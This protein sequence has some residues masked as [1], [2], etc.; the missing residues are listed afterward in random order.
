MTL[1]AATA[2]DPKAFFRE[3]PEPIRQGSSFDLTIGNI[4][5][6]KGREV[7][8]PFTLKAGH[9]V[10][11][12]SAQVFNLP[13]HITGHVTY[14]T[15]LTRKGIWALTV[16]IVD[17]GWTGPI[18]T[19]LLN[20]SKIDHVVARGD[21]FLRVSFFEH[22][23]VPPDLLRTAPSPEEYCKSVQKAAVS[24]FPKTFLAHKEIAQR[25]GEKAAAQI[26]NNALIWAA[27]IGLYFAVI[28]AVA[29]YFHP[30]YTSAPP[31][32][33][34]SAEELSRLQSELDIMRKRIGELERAALLLRQ[35]EA[36][37]TEQ[38]APDTEAESR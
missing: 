31:E 32:H 16:G 25:A 3:G 5:D 26:R 12:S 2:L 11:V 36:D 15:T 34:V 29:I 35:D 22:T 14:K 21:A 38:R 28:Q 37:S 1:L 13:S 33:V 8:G 30:A 7:T 20:F 19:T 17:P 24:D 6:R 9:M 10:Q 23:P 18:A 4:Y 27:G